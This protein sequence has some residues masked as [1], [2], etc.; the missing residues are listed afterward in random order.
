MKFKGD[1]DAK[2][3]AT[4]EHLI[5]SSLGG[6]NNKKNLKLA[7]KACNNHRNRYPDNIYPFS[8]DEYMKVMPIHPGKIKTENAN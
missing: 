8:L 7:C 3:Y 2:N 5:P 4:L 1:P 6:S